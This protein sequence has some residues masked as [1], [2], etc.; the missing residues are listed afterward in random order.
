MRYW[1]VNNLHFMKEIGNQH[2]WRLNVW[3]GISGPQVIG[4]QYFEKTLNGEVYVFFLIEH[5]L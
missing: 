3:C 2:V 5:C 1:V 4:S